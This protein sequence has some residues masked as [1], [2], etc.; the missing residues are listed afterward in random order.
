MDVALAKLFFNVANILF[1]I[2]SVSLIRDF[3]KNPIKYKAWSCWLTFAAMLSVQAGYIYLDD[4]L[5]LILAVPTVFYW[6]IASVYSIYK[7]HKYNKTK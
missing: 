5:S 3:I 1:I 4:Q 2:G 7:S 6:G